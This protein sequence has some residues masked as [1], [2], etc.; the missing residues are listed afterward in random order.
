M[1]AALTSI[2]IPTYNRAHFLAESLDSIRRQ[3]YPN[4]EIVISDNHS[5]DATEALCRA[6]AAED[7]RIRYIRQRRNLGM[8][9][10]H[11]ACID[12]SR[13]DFLAFFHDDDVYSEQMVSACVAFLRERPHVGLVC[14]DWQLID[15]SGSMLGERRHEVPA[16]VDGTDYIERTMRSGQS[17]LGCPGTL[18]RRA[19]LGDIRFDVNG[20]LGFGDFAVWF[21][22]AERSA[23]GHIDRILWRYR[24]HTQSLSRRTILSVTGDYYDSLD[25]YCAGYLQR[26]PDSGRRVARWRAHIRRYLFWAVAYEVGLHFR[27]Q[28]ESTAARY[29]TVFELADYRLTPEELDAALAHLRTYHQGA[30]Q[31]GVWAVVALLVRAR[32]TAPLAWAA[33]HPSLMRRVGGLS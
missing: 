20:P 18:I 5:T 2:C 12:E 11:N 25:R 22:V 30:L 21:Q 27:Q 17:F 3:D 9:A 4:L 33:R 1:T 26:R 10:N 28:T 31:G 19:S 23:V 6:A 16:V 24:L 8:H 13:G 29:R 7:S 32:C 14:P 15:E